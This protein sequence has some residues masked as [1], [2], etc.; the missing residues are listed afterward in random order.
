MKPE[1][2][3]IIKAVLHMLQPMHLLPFF[4]KEKGIKRA[5]PSRKEWTGKLASR[6]VAQVLA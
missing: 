2:I 4:W 5:L 1:F 6:D 3:V